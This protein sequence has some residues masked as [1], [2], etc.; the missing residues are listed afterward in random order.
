[1]TGARAGEDNPPPI[2]PRASSL[3]ESAHNYGRI[4]RKFDID[5]C[6]V[7]DVIM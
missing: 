6:T 4:V 5:F 7:F 2:P 1:M 3:R